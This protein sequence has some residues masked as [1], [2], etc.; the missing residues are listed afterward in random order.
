MP[1]IK[2]ELKK[3]SK[4]EPNT[5]HALILELIQESNAKDLIL[6]SKKAAENDVL[7]QAITNKAKSFLSSEK[8][9]YRYYALE[10]LKNMNTEEADDIFI[11]SL[12]YGDTD[13]LRVAIIECGKR[14]LRGSVDLIIE[15]VGSDKKHV[16]RNAIDALGEIGDKKA[17][18]IIIK[19][20]DYHDSSISNSIKVSYIAEALEKLKDPKA[21]PALIRAHKSG[22][23]FCANTEIVNAIGAL[24]AEEYLDLLD[25]WKKNSIVPAEH[26]AIKAVFGKIKTPSI[27][28]YLRNCLNGSAASWEETI[29]MLGNTGCIEAAPTI[30]DG[31]VFATFPQSWISN[32][33][34]S[35]INLSGAKALLKLPQAEVLE[36]LLWHF[37]DLTQKKVPLQRSLFYDFCEPFIEN[38]T[39]ITA[40]PLLETL[41]DYHKKSIRNAALKSLNRIK[42]IL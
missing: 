39:D 10:S 35:R 27:I 12:N 7:A 24:G 41:V 32:G 4:L 9:N 14:K 3:M 15:H 25:G 5:Q 1:N 20:I 2:R 31:T 26:A 13:M 30:L 11:K 38:I 40:Q 42:E 19:Q 29:V 22:E 21:I 34:L 18:D 33:S 16:T 36:M 28:P 23:V 8:S 6:I 37:E 17:V